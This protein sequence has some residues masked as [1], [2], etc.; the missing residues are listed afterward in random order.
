MLY[1]FVCFFL[2]L[3]C[4]LQSLVDGADCSAQHAKQIQSLSPTTTKKKQRR[5]LNGG[6]MF[7]WKVV[8]KP[9][10]RLKS[11]ESQRW[12]RA[13]GYFR[14]L[15]Y[16]PTMGP[17]ERGG[18]SISAA[19]ESEWANR[20]KKI[21][22]FNYVLIRELIKEVFAVVHKTTRAMKVDQQIE[23]FRRSFSLVSS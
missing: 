7:W 10:C 12:A 6:K 17:H 13:R 22:S 14:L 5:V 16:L 20:K 3:G 9:S 21:I 8:E 23:F 4:Y 19:A 1:V 11:M 2:F 18:G 15:N